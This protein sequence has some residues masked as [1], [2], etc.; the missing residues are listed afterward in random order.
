M[1]LEKSKDELT[2]IFMNNLV[3]TNRGYNYYVDWSN[4]TGYDEFSIE[5]KAIDILIGLKNDVDFKN[6]FE[7]LLKK[8]PK[9]ICIFP[10]LFGLSKGERDKALKGKYD[11]T[12][13]SDALGSEDNLSYKFPQAT[14]SLSDVEIEKYYDLFER[15]GLKNLYQNLIDKSTKDYI[16][17]VLVGMDSNGRKNRG[18]SAFELACQPIFEEACKKLELTLLT[19]KQFAVLREYNFTISEDIL[20]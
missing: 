9:T 17:G 12:V 5:I 8:L 14:V 19:Q 4:I 1:L 20:I 16:I 11:L 6:E 15:L 2:D 13:V 7:R 18:G 3:S 10:L